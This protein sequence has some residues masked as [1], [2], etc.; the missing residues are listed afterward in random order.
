M[1]INDIYKKIIGRI[2]DFVADSMTNCGHRVHYPTI[3]EGDDG[4]EH[5]EEYWV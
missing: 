2:V 4:K 3:V 1:Q 5:V